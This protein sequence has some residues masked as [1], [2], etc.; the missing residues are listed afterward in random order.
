MSEIP[1]LKYRGKLIVSLQS[2]L[3]DSTALGLQEAVLQRIETGGADGLV[4]D[5][6]ALEMVDSFIARVFME[7]GHMAQ[8]MNVKT[9]LVGMKPEVALTLVQMGFSLSGVMTA[10]DLESGLDLLDRSCLE[11]GAA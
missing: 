3:T 10:T 7:T 4:I 5:I 6:S 9:A 11:E 1:V 2:E 8:L